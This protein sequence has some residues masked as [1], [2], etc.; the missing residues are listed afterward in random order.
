MA[1][2]SVVVPVYNSELYLEKCISSILGQTY[3]N[4]ELILVDDGSVDSSPTICDRWSEKD[5]RVRVL[6]KK[7]GGIS[8]A[9]FDGVMISKGEYIG[10]VDSDDWIQENY[11]QTLY[12]NLLECQADCV[13]CGHTDFSK[14]EQTTFC[15]DYKTVVLSAEEIEEKILRPFWEECIN[16]NR[17]WSVSR[18]DKLFRADKLKACIYQTTHDLSI[19]E[20]TEMNL[21]YLPLCER[22]VF[23]KGYCGYMYR[24][25][26]DSISL[27]YS[28]ILLEHTCY[29]ERALQNVAASQKRSYT[30]QKK[31]KHCLL[32]GVLWRIVESEMT[33]FEKIQ[34]CEKV[35]TIMETPAEIGDYFGNVHP[36]LR[37]GFKIMGQGYVKLGASFVHFSL[38]AI[39]WIKGKEQ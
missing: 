18:W 9:V 32:C 7:N 33:M 13:G 16:L 29:F 1:M 38:K 30:A 17:D 14:D 10:F 36:V 31:R 5:G 22:V 24:Q 26:P 6:H 12:E 8:N 35:Y 2:I 20:D 34:E 21:L 23:L 27:N 39:W 37:L 4:L 3:T 28:P 25:R 11:Y 15:G 19:G